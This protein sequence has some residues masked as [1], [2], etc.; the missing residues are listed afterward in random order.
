M[1]ETEIRRPGTKLFHFSLSARNSPSGQW[2]KLR[3][4]ALAQNCFT[5]RCLRE[6]RLLVIGKTEIR[7]PGTKLLQFSL[8]ARNSPSGQW[9]QMRFG[10]V[11]RNFFTFRCRLVI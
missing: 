9:Y 4:G 7:R 6:I 3:F 2:S 10:A 1:V 5:F 8:S 11:E